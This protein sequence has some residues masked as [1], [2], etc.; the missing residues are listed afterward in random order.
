MQ[1]K[2][3]SMLGRM[4]LW[5]KPPA[6]ST[7]QFSSKARHFHLILWMLTLPLKYILSATSN[8]WGVTIPVASDCNLDIALL[9]VACQRTLP[10]M[11]FSWCAFLSA[12]RNPHFR[13]HECSLLTSPVTHLYNWLQ[14]APLSWTDI[15]NPSLQ[16]LCPSYK[17]ASSILFM[18]SLR[19]STISAIPRLSLAPTAFNVACLFNQRLRIRQGLLPPANLPAAIWVCERENIECSLPK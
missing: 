18:C 13:A 7:S 2:S 11:H 15:Q 19:C 3:S 12:R 9:F 6:S 14:N 17:A 10:C 1:Y 8:S 16:P 4:Y 5:G